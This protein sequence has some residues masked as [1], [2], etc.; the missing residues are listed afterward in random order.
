MYLNKGQEI[1][2]DNFRFHK[3]ADNNNYIDYTNDLNFRLGTSTKITFD[4]M[5]QM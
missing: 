3:G 4:E 5:E 1:K 2:I